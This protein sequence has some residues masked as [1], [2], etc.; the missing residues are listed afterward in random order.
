MD[1]LRQLVNGL[2]GQYDSL[3]NPPDF[4][5]TGDDATACC[6]ALHKSL[7]HSEGHRHFE[8]G[9]GPHRNL[10]VLDHAGP[11]DV[12]QRRV[13]DE[14]LFTRYDRIAALEWVSRM[15]GEA[16]GKVHRMEGIPRAHARARNRGGDGLP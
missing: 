7:S 13:D 1:G 5:I 8:D 12:V 2:H 3:D 16:Q 6:S 14:E 9:A 15:S 4:L 11:L 10:D